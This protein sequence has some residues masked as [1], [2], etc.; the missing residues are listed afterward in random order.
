MIESQAGISMQDNCLVYVGQVLDEGLTLNDCNV[1]AHYHT[2]DVH[3]KDDTGK[4]GL[5]TSLDGGEWHNIIRHVTS[6][7]DIA[8]ELKSIGICLPFPITV[9]S[10]KR[11]HGRCTLYWAKIGGWADIRG[12]SIVFILERAPR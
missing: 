2:I 9:P 6:Y 1:R 12:I 7:Y 11:A 8:R 10:R 5:V 4:L 3:S